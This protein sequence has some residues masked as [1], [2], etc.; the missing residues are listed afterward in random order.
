MKV[1]AHRGY[2]SQ[3]P[4]NTMAAFGKALDVGNTH[5]ELD[6][7]MTKDGEVVVIHDETVDRTSDGEGLVKDLTLDQ[8]RQ[9]DFGSWFDE[10]FTAERIPLLSDVLQTASEHDVWLNIELKTGIVQYPEIEQRVIDLIHQYDMGQQVAISS[11]NHYSLKKV[12]EICPAMPIG[13]LYMAG[14]YE[15]WHY[16]AR[17]GAEALHPLYRSIVPEIVAGAKAA[18]IALR[19]FTVDEP[20]L[21]QR[22]IAAGVDGIITNYPER[23]AGLLA[24][25]P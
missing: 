7:Q 17:L 25:K 1:I 10:A 20:A 15:P 12:K 16:A 21:I 4:E 6:V 14:L 19:P 24:A 13:L 5:W 9:L 8:L 2:S 23:A 18:G 22:M 3:A 11:F